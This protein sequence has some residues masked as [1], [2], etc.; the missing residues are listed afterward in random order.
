LELFFNMIV[1]ISQYLSAISDRDTRIIKLL[2]LKIM[3]DK[4][5]YDFSN[6]AWMLSM[7]WKNI[8]FFQMVSCK[9]KIKN[10]DR[11]PDMNTSY[12]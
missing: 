6:E 12:C 2:M 9:C 11:V 8:I 7:D 4:I 3:I 5:L 1:N 10:V